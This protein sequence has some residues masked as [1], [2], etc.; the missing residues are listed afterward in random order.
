[1][2]ELVALGFEAGFDIAQ[3]FPVGELSKSHTA[4]LILATEALDVLV[5]IVALNATA[6][7]MQRQMIHCLCENEFACKH[8]LNALTWNAR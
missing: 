2:I 8:R 5:A 6:K 4:T 7:G 3:T 1:M